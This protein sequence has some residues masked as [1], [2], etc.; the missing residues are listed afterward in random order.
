MS[1]PSQRF[2]MVAF[3]P[4]N[5]NLL[6]P[7]QLLVLADLGLRPS[8]CTLCCPAPTH[9]GG[10]RSVEASNQVWDDFGHVFGSR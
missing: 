8:S 4:R 2:V 6:T 10:S 1:I 7:E 3:T 5:V 9:P